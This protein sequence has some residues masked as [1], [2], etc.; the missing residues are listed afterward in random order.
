MPNHIINYLIINANDLLVKQIRK[1]IASDEGEIDFNKIYPMP[2]TLNIEDGSNMDYAISYFLSAINPY[3]EEYPI[4]KKEYEKYKEIA[5]KTGRQR[6]FQRVYSDNLKYKDFERFMKS[7][8]QSNN[9]SVQQKEII[10][11]LNMGKQYLDNHEKYDAPTWYDWRCREWGTKWNAYD[12]KSLCS[13]MVEFLTAWN[14]PRE[15]I[16]KLSKMFTDAE[17]TVFYADEDYNSEN[18]GIYSYCNDEYYEYDRCD[19]SQENF[20]KNIWEGLIYEDIDKFVDKIDIDIN[21]TPIEQEDYFF[22]YPDT[23][24]FEAIYYNPNARA[25]GQ[26]VIQNIPYELIIKAKD[27]TEDINDFFNYLQENAYTELVDFGTAE[28]GNML[29]QYKKPKPECIGYSEN[30]M[31]IL[32]S[33]AKRC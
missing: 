25:G 11:F 6:F 16:R 5:N 4:E 14:T 18:Y 33:K 23:S 31:N 1:F 27:N 30:T 22:D 7:R 8:I 17:F 9:P 32:L 15:I 13:Y 26:F 12:T 2:E 21:T 19:I 20:S 28:F 3:N 24:K 10:D 29:E